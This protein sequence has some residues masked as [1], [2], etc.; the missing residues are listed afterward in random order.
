MWY[1]SVAVVQ[2]Q[3]WN[4]KLLHEL[5]LITLVEWIFAVVLKFRRVYEAA[6]WNSCPELIIIVLPSEFF[7]EV[8]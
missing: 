5:L 7:I 3:A 1:P 6:E 8:Q 4:L 2:H